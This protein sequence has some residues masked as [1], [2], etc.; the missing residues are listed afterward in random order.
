MAYSALEN[1][2]STGVKEWLRFSDFVGRSN[3]REFWIFIGLCVSTVLL[4][5]AVASSLAHLGW[6]LGAHVAAY[7]ATVIEI[8]FLVPAVA[9]I[10]RR[11]QDTRFAQDIANR[12]PQLASRPGINVA[13]LT[14]LAIALSVV[15]FRYIGFFVLLFPLIMTLLPSDTRLKSAP[16]TFAPPP[17][18]A[19][20]LAGSPPPLPGSPTIAIS[21]G[22]PKSVVASATNALKQKKKLLAR[23]WFW[24]TVVIALLFII[25]SLWPGMP[26]KITNGWNERLGTILNPTPAP[27]LTVSPSPTPSEAGGPSPTPTSTDEVSAGAG[28]GVG[29][30]AG[31]GSE[32][33]DDIAVV[34]PSSDNLDPQFRYC[35][36]AIAAGFGPYYAG[37]DPE[38]AWYQDRDGDG[39]VCER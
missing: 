38:Y 19:S 2:L 13:I 17:T 35:T 20:H 25:L 26:E 5:E 11:I 23:L 31:G 37:K 7:F 10:A 14:G 36:H 32:E 34:V 16:R 21:P 33:D 6:V 3:L 28:A 18:Y 15:A 12:V 27:T 24:I 8:F 4:V 9:A 22:A 39:I 29:G 30:G 1:A